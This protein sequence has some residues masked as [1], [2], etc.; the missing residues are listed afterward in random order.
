MFVVIFL[1]LQAIRFYLSYWMAAQQSLPQASA[2]NN[3][4]GED[5][6]GRSPTFQD[7]EKGVY[8]CKHYKRNC[9]L[10]ATCCNK[11]FTCRFCHDIGSDHKMDW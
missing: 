5:L 3:C 1:T 8:G 9:K 2:G 11:L 6:V 7:S 10:H 4:E